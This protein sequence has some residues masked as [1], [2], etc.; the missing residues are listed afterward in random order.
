MRSAGVRRSA[1]SAGG[2]LNRAHALACGF[3]VGHAVKMN[4]HLAPVRDLDELT[5]EQRR[6]LGGVA[7]RIPR[8]IEAVRAGA[9]TARFKLGTRRLDDGRHIELELVAREPE[10]K[11]DGIAGSW[12]QVPPGQPADKGAHSVDPGGLGS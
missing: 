1:R 6:F 5:V 2:A 9:A 3:Q 12:G 8:L 7:A 10:G 4:R 11:W